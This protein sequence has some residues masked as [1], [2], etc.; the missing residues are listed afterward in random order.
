M[1][2]DTIFQK[3]TY[4]TLLKFWT[5]VTLHVLLLPKY[6]NYGVI[7]QVI[8]YPLAVNIPQL[9][10]Q[11]NKTLFE[12]KPFIQI[13]MIPKSSKSDLSL[14][15]IVG[16]SNSYGYVYWKRSEFLLLFILNP[17]TQ[18]IAILRVTWLI[19]LFVFSKIVLCYA[20][21]IWD[22]GLTWV[23]LNCPSKWKYLLF[24]R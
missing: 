6:R 9:F 4:G 1:Y 21:Y 16:I 15:Y 10:K 11:K 14:Y 22:L 13:K 2:L 7:Y 8:S 24:S 23:I 19:H 12:Q 3:S 17:L 20:N 5:K 18:Q